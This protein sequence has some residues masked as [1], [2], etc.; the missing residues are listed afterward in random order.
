MTILSIGL[1]LVLVV[2]WVGRIA[3]GLRGDL[4]K[5]MLLGQTTLVVQAI[6]LGLVVPLAVLTGVMTWKRRPVGYLLS[7]VLVVKAVAM[8]AA[9]CA[10]LL[11]AWVTEGKLD[12]GPLVLFAGAMVAAAWIGVL[13][14]RSI[15]PVQP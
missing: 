7:P 6:D 15:R 10:M 1:A 3:S 13:M 8:A 9:I 12:V 11:S 14:Y 4:G 2:M 5:A